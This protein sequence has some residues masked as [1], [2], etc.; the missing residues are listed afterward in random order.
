MP[1]N[2]SSSIPSDE[3]DHAYSDKVQKFPVVNLTHGARATGAHGRGRG[4]G[5]EPAG[6]RRMNKQLYIILTA[7][8]PAPRSCPPIPASMPITLSQPPHH[9]HHH[10]H[11]R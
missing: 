1:N 9:H 3:A 8:S 10:H 7:S 6:V 11:Q 5:R 4:R 2:S